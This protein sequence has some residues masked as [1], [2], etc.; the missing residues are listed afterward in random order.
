MHQKALSV[1][2]MSHTGSFDGEH[3][4]QDIVEEYR[5]K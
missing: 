2:V 5:I 1:Q 3:T 4:L